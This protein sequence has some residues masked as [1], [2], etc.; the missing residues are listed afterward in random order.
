[1]DYKAIGLFIKN[2]RIKAN[3]TQRELANML[4]VT[5]KAV[6]KWERGNGCPDVSI[7]ESLSNV[8]DVSILEILNGK[9][10]ENISL[11]DADMGIKVSLIEDR[12]KYKKIACL[13]ISIFIICMVFMVFVLN[14]THIFYLNKKITYDFTDY[15]K[16]INEL[17]NEFSSKNDSLNKECISDED[18]NEIKK[19]L[20]EIYNGYKNLKINSYDGVV[21]LNKKDLYELDSE[22][23]NMLDMVHILEIL[24]KY[25][26]RIGDYYDLFMDEF[27]YSAYGSSFAYKD[28]TD[29]SFYQVNSILS[30][31]IDP[32]EFRTSKAKYL[33]KNMIY[34]L[35]YIGGDICE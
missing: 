21:S 1:M 30:R 10:M 31:D 27:R 4:G 5:D 24:S 29:S 14:I 22:K 16:E 15:H 8:L 26:S 6:S 11:F 34:I 28:I 12:N 17:L 2:R 33:L 7:L 18:F 35:S 25:S 13:I 9:R 19:D 23:Y 3:L 20:N 32:M